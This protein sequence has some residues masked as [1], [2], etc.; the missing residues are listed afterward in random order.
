MITLK[1]VDGSQTSVLL[2]IHAGSTEEVAIY[3]DI[4]DCVSDDSHFIHADDETSP[5]LLYFEN[6]DY[7]IVRDAPESLV[8]AR[9]GCPLLSAHPIS[10]SPSGVPLLPPNERLLRTGDRLIVDSRGLFVRV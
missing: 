6:F 7:Q 2:R 8:T 4:L 10:R 9:G 3:T 5:E 1:I